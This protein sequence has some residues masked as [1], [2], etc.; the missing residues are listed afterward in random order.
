MFEAFASILLCCYV[1]ALLFMH[2]L[3]LIYV[4]ILSHNFLPLGLFITKKL[5]KFNFFYD[6]EKLKTWKF[7][8]LYET[9]WAF[10][11]NNNQSL[12][13]LVKIHYKCIISFTIS[14]AFYIIYVNLHRGNHLN[15]V[16]WCFLKKNFHKLF[17][18]FFFANFV[19]KR[20]FTGALTCRSF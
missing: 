20:T 9:F 17:F 18:I 5:W 14:E 13:S 19:K 2:I 4:W 11:K 15:C 12:N 1:H 7:V 6:K 3:C 16:L 10:Y 8:F